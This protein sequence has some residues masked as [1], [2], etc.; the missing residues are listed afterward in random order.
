MFTTTNT[1]ENNKLSWVR[2]H[3]L[4]SVKNKTGQNIVLLKLRP[5]R[6]LI[7]VK[8]CLLSRRSGI[9]FNSRLRTWDP[10]ATVWP[11]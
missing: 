3:I 10:R 1:S 2:F 11:P 5:A 9:R 4:Q 6:G 8:F 7:T